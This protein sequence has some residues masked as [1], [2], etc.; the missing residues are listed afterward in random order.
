MLE[1]K[2]I[3]RRFTVGMGGGREGGKEGGREGGRL[4]RANQSIVLQAALDNYRDVIA[5]QRN[6]GRPFPPSLPP[7][8]PPSFLPSLLSL[9]LSC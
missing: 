1:L 3:R 4:I 5:T 2:E 7:S 6:L 8:L 9:H